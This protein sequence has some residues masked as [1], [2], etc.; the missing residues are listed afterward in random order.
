MSTNLH[1]PAREVQAL[2]EVGVTVV[3]WGVALGMVLAFAVTIFGVALLEPFAEGLEEVSDVDGRETTGQRQIFDGFGAEVQTA[4]VGSGGEGALAVNRS[5]LAAMDRFEDRLEEQS[6]LRRWLLPRLQWRLAAATGLGNEQV[7]IGER[8]WL[9]F[10][11]DVD[12]VVGRGFLDPR[13]QEA[14]RRGGDAWLP[15]PEPDPLPALMD[16]QEQLRS[17]QIHL[18]VMPTPVKPTVEPGRFSKRA[19]DT[20][21]ALQNLSFAQFQNQVADLGIDV[22][23]PAPVLVKARL[24]SGE[25]QYL[26][27]DTHWTP[28]AVE[29][30]ARELARKIMAALVVSEP[31]PGSYGR[32]PVIVESL[33]DIAGMLLLPPAQRW[34]SAERVT[35]QL[36]IRRDGRAWQV[37]KGAEILLLGDSFTNVYSDATLGWGA[38]AGL[39]EQ[40]SYCLQRPVDRMAVNAGG[41]LQARKTLQRALAGR[42]DRLAGKKVVVYQFA[43]RELTQGDWQIVELADADSAN[44]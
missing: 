14:R 19:L 29:T 11:P 1:R 31:D 18:I 17:R 39:A 41:A 26:R 2:E 44:R 42:E 32:R 7:Y 43:V 12:Y 8:E 9:F 35:T 28:D 27:T 22:L 36:V 6:F 20:G 23:D 25:S 10:R 38:G 16:L 33:G 3:S 5:L 15:A 30:V 34:I 40:L 13:V 21:G 24:E 4:L 37:E